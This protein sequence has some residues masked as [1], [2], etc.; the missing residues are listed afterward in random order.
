[1]TATKR[2]I[3]LLGKLAPPSKEDGMALIP[4]KGVDSPRVEKK[5][6]VQYSFQDLYLKDTC[7][8]SLLA[9]NSKDFYENFRLL[10][11]Y[12]WH[13]IQHPQDTTIT[14]FRLHNHIKISM[15]LTTKATLLL[16]SKPHNI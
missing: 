12:R 9:R 1:M 4:N 6:T 14:H 3:D 11:P 7:K 5:R 16:L 10:S 15:I 13:A 2:E 8:Y